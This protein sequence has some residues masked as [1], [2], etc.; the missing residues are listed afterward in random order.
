[1]IKAGAPK[2]SEACRFDPEIDRLLY[3]NRIIGILVKQ[4]HT[5]LEPREFPKSLAAINAFSEAF[6]SELETNLLQAYDRARHPV[7]FRP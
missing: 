7:D 1:M 6:N 3:V 2:S 5:L 4:A